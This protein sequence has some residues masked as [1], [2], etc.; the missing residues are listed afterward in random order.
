MWMYAV[1]LWFASD[2]ILGYIATPIIFYPLVLI[3]SVVFVAWQL[4]L[5]PVLMEEGVP[6][7][8]RRV[9]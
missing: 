7:V 4:E 6:E 8:K 1:L 3:G 5:L 9:N 2:N